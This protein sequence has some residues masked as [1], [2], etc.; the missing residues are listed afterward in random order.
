[1]ELSGE[2]HAPGALRP[3]KEPS[4]LIGYEVGWA[5][6]SVFYAVERGSFLTPD[7]NG[8]AV[9][10]LVALCYTDCDIRVP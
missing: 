7:G 6:N 2:I 4:V 5:P 10:Q 3:R 9:V 1:M 8:T